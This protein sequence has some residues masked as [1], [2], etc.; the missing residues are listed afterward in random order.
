MPQRGMKR[1]DL[2]CKH[3]I[4]IGA[5]VFIYSDRQGLGSIE[6]RGM[7]TK[8]GHPITFLGMEPGFAINGPAVSPD[9]QE[10]R[11]AIMIHEDDS[12]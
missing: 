2:T 8:C 10:A 7:C 1:T 4:E 6:L 11:L 12:N 9:G 5:D 3:E